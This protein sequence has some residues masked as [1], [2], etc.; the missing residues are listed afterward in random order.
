MESLWPFDTKMRSAVA[1]TPEGLLPP[2]IPFPNGRP[3]RMKA[4]MRGAEGF[5]R[6]T[7]ASEFDSCAFGSPSPG[8]WTSPFAVARLTPSTASFDGNPN[9]GKGSPVS[10]ACLL[11]APGMDLYSN[12]PMLVT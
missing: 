1:I 12:I 8:T 6:L 11:S 4:S 9:A 2:W 3:V 7:T 10:R 5:S